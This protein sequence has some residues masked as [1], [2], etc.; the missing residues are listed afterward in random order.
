[1]APE[2][3]RRFFLLSHPRSASNLLVRMLGLDQ[4]PQVA[5]R[6]LNGYFFIESYF[7]SDKLGLR[8]KNVMDWTDD[9]RTQMRHAYQ[10]AFDTLQNH[11]SEAEKEGK[12]VFVKEHSYL[13][14]EPVHQFKFHYGEDSVTEGPWTLDV[15]ESYGTNLTRSEGNITLLPDEFLDT[16]NPIFLIRHPALMF[17]SF[18]RAM[19]DVHKMDDREVDDDM[20]V[21]M[22]IL[23]SLYCPRTTY[24]WYAK[25]R[26]KAGDS[27]DQRDVCPIVVDADDVI[28]HPEVVLKLSDKIGLDRD[29]LR[30]TWEAKIIKEDG[31]INLKS[32]RMLSTL[33]ASQ[34]VLKDK[35]AGNIDIDVEAKKWREEFGEKVAENLNRLVRSSMPDYEYLKDKRMRPS[36]V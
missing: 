4:Q 31:E 25:R 30:F 33:A 23:M 5:K 29:S 13:L 20:W 7:L 26:G 24:D 21:D 17:P 35:A 10:G 14:L 3:D 27:E 22:N 28:N 8:L 1:M 32:Q 12:I 15:H 18:Y 11:V 16:W 9:E 36:Q 34:A 19:V 2:R 6:W